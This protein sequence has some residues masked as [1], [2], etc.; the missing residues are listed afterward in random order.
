MHRILL[1]AK[2]DYLASV[3]S[4]AFL[5]GLIV[6]PILFGGGFIGLAVMRGKPDLADRRV[7]IVDRT[8]AAGPMI[9]AAAQEKN[10][11]DRF[12][13]VT[14]KQTTPR[15]VLETVAPDGQDGNAQLLAL[16][17]RVRK[18]ELFAFID[19]GANALRP[20][21]ETGPGKELPPENL[22]SYFSNAGGIDEARMWLSGPVT[23]G[24]RRVKLT[25]LGVDPSHF[26][27]LFRAATLQTMSLVSRDE[28]TGSIREARQKKDLESFIVP[29]VVTLLL[30]MIVMASSAPMLGAIAE[31]KMQR[32]YE[33]LLGKASPFELM[34]GKVIAAVGLSLTSSL[35]YVVGGL[36]VLQ[37]MAMTGL[38]PLSLLPWF[39]VY[40]IA[41]VMIL[42]SFAAALGAACG[43]P[44]DAQQ[45]GIVLMAPVMIPMF[46][47][48][49]VMQ[50]PNGPIA[51]VVS[52]MPPFTPVV[53][54]MRQAMPGGIPAWQPWVA[55]AGVIVFTIV[56]GWGAARVFRI[57]ILLQGKSPKAAEVVRWA[58]KG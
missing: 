57:A 48:M 43:S 40:L 28:K 45:L 11:R 18:R 55:L 4:K 1:I 6:A 7:A 2:R 8:G 20:P 21:P 51:T 12:D 33:M 26:E 16:S 34:M 23:E 27:D 41:D 36:A 5:F 14:G 42:S 35:F 50:Q 9:I 15:Y 56:M 30:A 54:L 25:R 38:A 13:K 31:D 53:M 52:L 17:D 44:H 46:L 3:K 39:V 29:F 47:M 32:V 10:A 19:I 22:I 24:I 49:P 37:S 58:I